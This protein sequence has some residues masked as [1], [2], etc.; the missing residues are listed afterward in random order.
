V[1][2]TVDLRDDA[3]GREV[4]VVAGVVVVGVIMSILDTTIVNVALETLSRD[5]HASLSSIQWVSTGYLLSLATVIPMAGWASERWGA[6]R[7][8]MISVALFVAGSALCGAAW[9]TE[10][11]IVFRVL[12]GFGGG[13]IMPV[14][15]SVLTQTAGPT[16]VGRVMSVIGVPML[17]GPVLG[18]VIGGLILNSTTWRWIFYVNVPIGALGL[19]LAWKLLPS[20]AGRTDAGRLDWTGLLLLSPGLAG[21]VFGL[22]ETETHGGIGAAIA[23]GPILAGIAL[24]VGFVL[25]ALRAARPLIDVRLFRQRQFAAASSTTFFLGA[26]LFGA[27]IVIPLYYQVARG[28]SPL[29]AGLLM[30]PQGLGAALVMPVAGRLTDRVGGGRVAIVGLL[31]CTVATLPFAFV[32]PHTSY[33][34]LAAILVVRGIGFGSAMMPSM[35]AAYATLERAAVPRAT[36]AL[37]VFQ[38]VGGSVGTAFLAVILQGRIKA[39]L[40]LTGGGQNA[41]RELPASVRQRVAEPLAHAFAQTFWWALALIAVA[42]IPAGILALLSRPPTRPAARLEVRPPSTPESPPPDPSRGRTRAPAA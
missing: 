6:K 11:L 19:A 29:T 30:A 38:R 32:G 36:S 26:G 14:G 23:F 4:W 8:W 24:V 7:V 28:E 33:A 12:Q 35:A 37:N 5:L 3:L 39:N 25:H 10:S 21:I 9:S 40:H 16:K 1:G 17:L 15:M 20:D 31:V 13:M 27:M 42:I 41:V 18:P 2:A 34:W 22:S